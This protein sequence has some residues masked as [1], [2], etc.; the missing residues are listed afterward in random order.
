MNRYRTWISGT[1]LVLAFVLRVIWLDLKPAHFDEGVNGAF[2]D[3]M[4][5]QGFYH[6]D[7]TNFH[8]PLHFYVLFVSQTL[9]GRDLWALR[10]PVV[11]VSTACIGLV[12]A[13]RR[14][15]DERACQL[16][17]L[18]MAVSPAMVF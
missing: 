7:P 18:A 2:V 9:F 17:A 11:L 1:I 6:Y 13:F 5:R 10:M 16:A 12:L 8:G 4:T 14:Y 15:F 3:Q